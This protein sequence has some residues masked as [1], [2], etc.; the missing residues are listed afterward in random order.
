MA[1]LHLNQLLIIE[2]PTDTGTNNS[3]EVKV[4]A[5]DGG[6]NATDQTL[7]VNILNVAPK[8]TGPSGGRFFYKF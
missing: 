4:R 1:L 6:G 8:I 3:Y 2:N 7:S 5:T